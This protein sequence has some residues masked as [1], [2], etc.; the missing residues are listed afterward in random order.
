[1]SLIISRLFRLRETRRG[2]IYQ[3]GERDEAKISG[4]VGSDHLTGDDICKLLKLRDDR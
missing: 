3:G 2:F 4:G 1:M